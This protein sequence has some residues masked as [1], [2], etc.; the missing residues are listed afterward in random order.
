MADF[1][2]TG[3]VRLNSDPA[4]KSTSKWT[5]AAGQMIADFAKQAS[6]KLAEVVKSGVDYN[7]TM[8][9]YLTNFKVMLGSEEAAA[10]K[11][12]EIRKMAAS[13]PFSLDDLTSGTQTLL[14]GSP[15]HMRG[16]GLVCLERDIRVG[17]TPA[18]AGKRSGR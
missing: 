7:A 8:E 14:Q 4:E 13:T 18:Y 16:K 10:T 11:L 1:S 2:I 15:P 5:V 12:S 17:I 6:S 9:S 3:E